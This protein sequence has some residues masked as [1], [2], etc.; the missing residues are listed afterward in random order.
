NL[1]AQ[2]QL[3]MI[4]ESWENYLLQRNDPQVQAWSGVR[5]ILQ[6]NKAEG[7]LLL[8]KAVAQNYETAAELKAAL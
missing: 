5:K 8:D 4:S 1:A 2:R 6:G 7:Q 3:A